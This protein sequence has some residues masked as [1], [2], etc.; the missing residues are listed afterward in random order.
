[1]SST[2]FFFPRLG[3]LPHDDDD[4]STSSCCSHGYS[5]VARRGTAADTVSD[6]ATEY[7]V[8]PYNY[9]AMLVMNQLLEV[10]GFCTSGITRY[11]ST[12]NRLQLLAVSQY[13]GLYIAW[14]CRWQLGQVLRHDWD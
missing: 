12:R 9:N 5:F 2:S 8:Y 1:M 10:P 3:R 4:G 14:W 13:S 6:S 11:Y 7:P